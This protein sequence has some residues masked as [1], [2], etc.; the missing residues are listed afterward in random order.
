[1]RE[2]IEQA[3]VGIALFDRD[4]RFVQVNGRLAEINGQPA[5][6]HIGKRP[7]ELLSG[8]P[9]EAY[10]QAARRALA[11]EV[12]E[13]VELSGETTA[14]PGVN[15]QWLESWAPVRSPDGEVVGVLAFVVETTDRRRAEQALLRRE[16]SDRERWQALAEL[17]G[18]MAEASTVEGLAAGF[19]GRAAAAAGAGFANLALLTADGRRLRLHHQASL[20]ENVAR[21]WQDVS[22]EE[23]VP[24]VDAVRR[25]EPVFIHSPK[26]NAERYPMLAADTDRAGLAATASIPLLDGRGTALGAVG[27]AWSEPQSFPVEVRAAL[28]TVAQLTSQSLERARLHEAEHEIAGELQRRLLPA[29]LTAPQGTA[30]SARYRAGHARLDVGGDWYEVVARPDGQAVIAIGDVVG[31]GP[32]A[33]AAMGQI[34][35]ALTATASTAGGP[36]ELLGR[37]EEFAGR[38]PDARYSTVWVAFLDPRDGDLRYACAGHLPPVLLAPDGSAGLLEQ[39]RSYPLW[40]AGPKSDRTEPRQEGRATVPAGG[41]LLLYTDGLIERRDTSLDDG[42]ARLLKAVQ[43][44]RSRAIESF[45]DALLDQLLP[46]ASGDD[47]AAL[48]C[49]Q[50]TEARRSIAADLPATPGAWTND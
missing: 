24:L 9:P 42:F 8:I 41:R 35:S 36:A 43:D 25:R 3:P 12:T 31:H 49:I 18:V 22:L 7:E 30:L 37:L 10:L 1:L 26:D 45:C 47:D 46:Q 5:S 14:L 44:H 21:R 39:G 50:R 33:A 48:L 23:P 38:T 6:A 11:G 17:A 29:G 4:I 15:R 13:A 32:R 2:V 34:R 20:D 16:L 28:D 19:A 27:F 40:A